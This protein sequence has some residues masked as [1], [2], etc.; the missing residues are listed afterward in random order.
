M[1]RRIIRQLGRKFRITREEE[2]YAIMFMIATLFII[3]LG[4][5]VYIA[6]FIESYR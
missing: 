4:V 3:V 6:A 2:E 1:I 5:V